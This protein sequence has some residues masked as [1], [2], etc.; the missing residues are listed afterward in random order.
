MIGASVRRIVAALSVAWLALLAAATLVGAYPLMA[1]RPS[2]VMAG[3][4]YAAGALLCHQLPERSF[5]L[6]G[7]Q[8]PVCARCMGI[9]AGAAIGALVAALAPLGALERAAVARAR[10]VLLAAALPS[11]VTLVYEWTTDITPANGI[12]AAAGVPLGALVAWVVTAASAP[13]NAVEIH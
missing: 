9:S 3:A 8:W 4:V 13:R 7:V 10:L 12:R 5:H 2:S 11:I 6:G 1:P